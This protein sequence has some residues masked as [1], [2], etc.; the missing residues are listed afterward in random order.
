V[1]KYCSSV[2]VNAHVGQD[3]RKHESSPHDG[4][5]KVHRQQSLNTTQNVAAKESDRNDTCAL[6]IMS[7]LCILPV[8]GIHNP[9]G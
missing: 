1:Q 7:L 9:S 4:G 5:M 8:A 2:Y 3:Q 6:R